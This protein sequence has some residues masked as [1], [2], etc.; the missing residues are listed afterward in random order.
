MFK[1]K[2]S[3]LSRS[4]VFAALA[5][6][7]TA[8][9]AQDANKAVFVQ[10]VP[11]FSSWV[12]SVVVPSLPAVPTT[13]VTTVSPAQSA[14]QAAPAMATAYQPWPV[15]LG[16][17]ELPLV[18]ATS[19]GNWSDSYNYQG[20]HVRL[21]V[22]D[23]DGRTLRPRSLSAPPAPGERF[24]IRVTPS[25]AAVA[26]VGLIYG[27]SWDA[28]RGGQLYPQAGMS[29]AIEAGQTADLPLEPNRFFVMGADETRLLFSV[30]HPGATE[31]QRSTQPA[32][33]QDATLGSSY[34]QLIPKDKQPAFEQLLSAARR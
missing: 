3:A 26:E 32:Y 8:V 22:L 13:G 11:A 29:V 12:D 7:V 21:L 18:G 19:H 25:F 33:R 24:R 20:M 17:P 27:P 14:A 1:F 23:R 2:P 5:S 28:K 10:P 30:R 16:A 15:I 34:L 31:A 6:A 4:L 9:V